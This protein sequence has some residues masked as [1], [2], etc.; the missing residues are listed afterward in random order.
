MTQLVVR[1]LAL[2]TCALCCA[3][4]LPAQIGGNG[5][6]GPLVVTRG[7]V[8]LDT[9]ARPGGFDYT[10]ITIAAG[11]ELRLMGSNPARLRSQGA[12]TIDGWL[13]ADGFLPVAVSDGGRGGPGGF[14]GGVGGRGSGSPGQGP[15][16]GC[17]GWASGNLFGSPGPASHAIPARAITWC[18]QTFG[19]APPTYGSAWPFDVRGGSG[20]GDR[21]SVL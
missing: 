13:N 3:A 21:K 19:S 5:A 6:D 8:T 18:G 15:G 9:S 16:G 2:V 11:A 20:T 7:T 4:R 10:S 14:G 12:V 17:A 1:P